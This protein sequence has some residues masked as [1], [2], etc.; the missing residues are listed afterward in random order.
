MK[1][2]PKICYNCGKEMH[3]ADQYRWHNDFLGDFTIDCQ[4]EEYFFCD[5]GE[6]RLAYS[7]CL[8][9]EQ[10][11][12]NRISLAIMNMANSCLGQLEKL[13]VTRRDLESI[14]N[15]SR[16]AINKNGKL[17]TLVYHITFK[18]KIFYLY[19]SIM[20]FLETG[21]GR[22]NLLPYINE[23]TTIDKSA[24][25]DEKDVKCVETTSLFA[26]LNQ[27]STN[28][29]HTPME[30]YRKNTKS[31]FASGQAIRKAN[32]PVLR[33]TSHKM[34]HIHTTKQ[35]FATSSGVLPS[36][37]ERTDYFQLGLSTRQDSRQYAH[38]QWH[39]DLNK[40]ANAEEF[41]TTSPIIDE[42]NLI[43][44]KIETIKT[45]LNFS[46]GEK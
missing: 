45:S 10:E 20:R 31:C 7:L 9:I 26:D 41:Y 8:R 34:I 18:G 16:Q 5:C 28:P 32:P 17:K 30:N 19:E 21:D 36:Q 22:F 35:S 46:K 33:Q 23:V 40:S 2:T 38:T 12:Q 6:E 13:V 42:T 24:M 29:L 3:T 39:T 4:P 15:V 25:M 11:E 37:E 43:L 1:L 27:S 44:N 14:M